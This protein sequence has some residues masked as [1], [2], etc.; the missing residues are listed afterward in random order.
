MQSGIQAR[1]DCTTEYVALKTHKKHRYILYRVPEKSNE[2]TIESL[3]LTGTRSKTLATEADRKSD[4]EQFVEALTA[5]DEKQKPVC[6]WGVYDFE[7]EQD[8][9]MRNKIVLIC[10]APELA[11]F[12]SKMVFTTSKNS[13][14]IA[15]QNI[16]TVFE[17][18][19]LESV[20]YETVFEKI[21]KSKIH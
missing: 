12:R 8:G 7:Y 9:G 18:S 20:S 14:V 17:A 2:I 21:T 1:E 5:V 6:R 11:S 16:S 15:C 3:G 19:D 10:W 13:M 4:Y